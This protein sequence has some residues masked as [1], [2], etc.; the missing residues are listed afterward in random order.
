MSLI[1][2]RE[3]VKLVEQG[4]ITSQPEKINGASIDL[5]LDDVIRLESDTFEDVDLIEKENIETVERNIS[6][7][8]Y[9]L[10][11][12]EFILAST[13]EWFNLPDDIAALYVCKSSMARNGLNHLNAG[14]ADPTWY[15]S[16]LTLEL[17]NVTKRKTMIL[18]PG[19]SI[20][21]MLFFRCSGSVPEHVSYA[22]VGQYNN[23]QS[24]TASKGIR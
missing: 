3:L 21:Q 14:F 11:P 8:C 12:G 24:V 19:M 2:H 5:T 15:G 4:V 23:Q 10:N 9:F 18:R 17:H 6:D 16:K 7:S 1:S 13:A 20:G 22:K